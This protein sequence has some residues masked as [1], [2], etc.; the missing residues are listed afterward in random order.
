MESF[1][2]L[3]VCL[4]NATE[5]HLKSLFAHDKFKPCATANNMQNIRSDQSTFCDLL[6]ALPNQ[7]WTVCGRKQIT[8]PCSLMS[9]V[10]CRSIVYSS[11]FRVRLAV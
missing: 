4:H 11:F 9:V 8:Y 1:G 6:T 10:I 7:F 2:V 5:Q 3:A